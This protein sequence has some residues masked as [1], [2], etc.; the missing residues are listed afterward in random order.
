MSE[1]FLGFVGVPKCAAF[2]TRKLAFLQFYSWRRYLFADLYLHFLGEVGKL[3]Q[4]T[5]IYL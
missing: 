4:V 5:L 1:I 2:N 3:L